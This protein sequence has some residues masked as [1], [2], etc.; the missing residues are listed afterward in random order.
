MSR[1][2]TV[3][4]GGVCIYCGHPLKAG[5]ATADHII[6][7]SRGGASEDYNIIACCRACNCAKDRMII[8]TFVRT[9]G[10]R[11]RIGFERR[12]ERLHDRRMISDE[13]YSL[14]MERSPSY[15]S[16]T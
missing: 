12:V 15:R 7:K 9:M 2:N 11:Q 5:K 6:P 14:L 3:E 4:T 16:W 13:K 1:A 10:P 8:P